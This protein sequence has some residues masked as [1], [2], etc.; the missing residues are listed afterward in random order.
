MR[1]DAQDPAAPILLG[2]GGAT[3]P[4]ADAK[5]A[6]ALRNSAPGA[7]E[8]GQRAKLAV[9]FDLLDGPEPVRLTV[10]G[11]TARALLA[12]EKAGPR[13]CTAL[14]V[15]S[16]AYRFAAYCHDLRRLGVSIRCDREQHAGGWHGRHVLESRVRIAEV[17]HG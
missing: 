17:R 7:R 1:P 12:L 8:Q 13:G 3:G 9:A 15:G 2:G 16:W 5:P 6:D 11:Q 10:R 14:E 4:G